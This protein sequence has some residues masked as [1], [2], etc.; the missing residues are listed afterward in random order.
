MAIKRRYNINFE[1]IMISIILLTISMGD[2]NGKLP[3]NLSQMA[4]VFLAFMQLLEM[5]YMKRIVVSVYSGLLMA[6]IVLVT[7]VINQNISITSMKTLVGIMIYSFCFYYYVWKRRKNLKTIL[8]L[9]VN[10]SVLLAVIGLIQEIGFLL[11]VKNLYSFDYLG[12]KTRISITSPFLRITSLAIEPAHLGYMLVPGLYMSLAHM[13]KTDNEKIIK[14]W[15][16]V[17]IFVAT[18]FTFSFLAYI[19]VLIIVLFL[20][21]GGKVSFIRKIAIASI[22]SIIVLFVSS[23][24]SSSLQVVMSKYNSLFTLQEQLDTTNLSSFAVVSNLNIALANAKD[25]YYLGSGL[26]TH[27]EAY[28][29]YIDDFYGLHRIIMFLNSEDASSLFIRILSEFGQVG[30]FLFVIF[31]IKFKIK[32]YKSN[33][34]VTQANDMALVTLIGFSMRNG[35]YLDSYLWIT[36]TMYVVSYMMFIKQQQGSQVL[37]PSIITS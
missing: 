2:L 12:I 28:Y 15:Q 8:K 16:C 9:L 26:N 37:A 20:L 4:V 25:H 31:L 32:K 11:S 29:K 14:I 36:L 17:V 21:L 27:Q 3:L 34:I 13:F 18:L 6:Y 23:A 7:V 33:N 1:D 10:I 22:L 30:L 24:F 35:T 5:L 19:N